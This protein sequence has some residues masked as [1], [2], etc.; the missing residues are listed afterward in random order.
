[1]S[2][3]GRILGAVSLTYTIFTL[4]VYAEQRTITSDQALIAMGL[5]ED[6]AVKINSIVDY[7][8]TKCIPAFSNK[9]TDFIFV[10]KKPVFSVSESKK[11]WIIV[12]VASVGKT[13]NDKPSYSADEVLFAD[14]SMVPSMKYYAIPAILAKSL[15]RD[16]FIGRITLNDMWERIAAA[17]KPFRADMR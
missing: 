8:S 10:S 9:G 15:Q 4:P 7:T 12:V 14:S 3:L 1:M 5:C 2:K 16:V 11:A 17:L 13:L 6:M